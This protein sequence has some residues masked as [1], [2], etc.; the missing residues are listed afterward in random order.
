MP[1][2]HIQQA[3]HILREGGII[4]YP[5]E[6]VFG[7]GCDPLNGHAVHDLLTIKKRSVNQGL[8]LIASDFNQ[9]NLYVEPLAAEVL[10]RVQS[11]WPGPHTWVLPASEHTPYWIKGKHSGV[12]VRV[13]AHP[14]VRA[15]CE[16]F[17][18]AMVSTSANHHGRQAAR[19]A[20]K[21]R[22]WFRDQI[23]FVLS[24]DIDP[25]SKPTE[26]RDAISNRVIRAA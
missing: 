23:D 18:G 20:L 22:N 5:T 24:G 8:I 12:A 7:L 21:V 13:T 2:I 6:A 19:S 25:N 4:A 26:I 17:G 9:L 10:S 1:R 3:A 11:S 16:S 14:V 15:L